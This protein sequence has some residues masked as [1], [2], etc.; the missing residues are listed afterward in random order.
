MVIIKAHM[1]RVLGGNDE[2]DG[3]AAL[4]YRIPRCPRLDAGWTLDRVTDAGTARHITAGLLSSDV[5]VQRI[6]QTAQYSRMWFRTRNNFS[7]ILMRT[8]TRCSLSRHKTTILENF[9]EFSKWY[10]LGHTFQLE[11]K[12]PTRVFKKSIP[13][14]IKLDF[15]RLTFRCCNM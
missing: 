10:Q 5:Y 14:F 8:E 6:S 4:Y 7:W 12:L 15:K 13:Y 2:E 1:L 11:L 9:L 3:K